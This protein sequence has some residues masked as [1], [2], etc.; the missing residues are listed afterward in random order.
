MKCLEGSENFTIRFEAF[1]LRREKVSNVKMPDA[2]S[3]LQ[4]I[5][6]SFLPAPRWGESG[7]PQELA[8]ACCRQP[9][10]EGVTFSLE[11]K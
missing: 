6:Y 5:L 8:A 10:A 2:F 3:F 7:R 4:F 1:V 9:E 11:T